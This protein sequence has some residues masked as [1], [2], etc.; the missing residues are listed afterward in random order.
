MET[1]IRIKVHPGAKKNA[2]IGLG[3]DSFEAWVRAK[4]IAG[5]AN[6][7]VLQLLAHALHVP[8]GCIRLVKG[9]GSRQKLFKTTH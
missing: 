2:L 4:P 5:Q 7:A 9:G 6:Q 3:T 1:W 8:P